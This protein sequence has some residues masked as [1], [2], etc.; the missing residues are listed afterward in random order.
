[1]NIISLLPSAKATR[2]VNAM[3]GKCNYQETIDEEPNPESREEFANRKVLELIK[4]HVEGWEREQAIKEI[5][6]TPFI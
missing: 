2:L 5:T 3:C 6:L 1:M 4:N